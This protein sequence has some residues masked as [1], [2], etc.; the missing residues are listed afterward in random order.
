MLVGDAMELLQVHQVVHTREEEPVTA[1]QPSDKRVVERAGRGFVS[2]NE[3]R[4][5]LLG[6]TALPQ[7]DQQLV[8]RC[9]RVAR[10]R[11]PN[12]GW[13][14]GWPAAPCFHGGPCGQEAPRRGGVR[15]RLCDVPV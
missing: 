7:Q 10:D 15:E 12:R 1:A 14:V 9:G 13:I 4:R 3:L 11:G 5:P 2:G 8:P 6:S